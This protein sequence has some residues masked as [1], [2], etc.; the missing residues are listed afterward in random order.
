MASSG[1]DGAF[2]SHWLRPSHFRWPFDG[3]LGNSGAARAQINPSSIP[4]LTIDH[5]K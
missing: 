2:Q 4:E 1:L 5:L 3:I